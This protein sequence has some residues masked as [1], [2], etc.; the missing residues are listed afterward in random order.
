MLNCRLLSDQEIEDVVAELQRPLAS[1]RLKVE[2]SA[3][4]S[5]HGPPTPHDTPAFRIFEQVSSQLWPGIVTLPYLAPAS[6]DAHVLDRSLSRSPRKLL[7]S[8]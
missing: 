7:T 2:V 1:D 3:R 4:S 8:A 6:S 5:G